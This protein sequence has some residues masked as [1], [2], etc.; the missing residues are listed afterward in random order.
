MLKLKVDYPTRAEEKEIIKRMSR[1]EKPSISP[2]I[3]IEEI[4]KL[5]KLVDEI[6]IEEHLIDY[7]VDVI[8][9]TRKPQEY[10]LE[11]ISSYIEY[12]ISPRGSIFLTQAAKAHAF[13]QHRGFVVPDDIKAVSLDVLRHRLILNY[14]AEAEDITPEILLNEIFGRIEVP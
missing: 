13:L 6:Y 8:Y 3:K 4:R 7:I 11:G 2:V 1:E 14:E 5:R 10:G 9:S 12:G